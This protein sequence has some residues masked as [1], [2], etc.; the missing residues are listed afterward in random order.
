MGPGRSLCLVSSFFLSGCALISGLSDFRRADCSGD[1]TCAAPG[2]PL[3]AATN[4]PDAALADAAPIELGAVLGSGP[5]GG[6]A[7]G[8]G[9][10]FGHPPNERGEAESCGPTSTVLHCS[11]CG[12]A[13]DTKTATS[14][15]CDGFECHY[16]CK[17]GFRDCDSAAPNL[18]GCECATPACCGDRCQTTHS[19]GVGGTFYDCTPAG[20]FNR[21]QAEAACNASALLG[22]TGSLSC[23]DKA[24]GA[25]NDSI[26]LAGLTDCTCWTYAGPNA[27]RVARGSGLGCQCPTATSATWN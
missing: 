26:C 18:D 17:A 5:A 8:G 2:D 11:A 27:G 6:E 23:S 20:T 4:A 10:E 9:G 3:L 25:S 22:L 15:S 13:C 14:A 24:C 7:Q 12:L 1:G 21:D 19:N 16:A